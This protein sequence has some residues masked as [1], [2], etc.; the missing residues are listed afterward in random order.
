MLFTL[1]Q[2]K[3]YAPFLKKGVSWSKKKTNPTTRGLSAVEG[4]TAEQRADDL[5]NMLESIKSFCPVIK[6]SS[7]VDNSKCLDDV[8]QAIRLHYGFNTSGANFLDFT[9]IKP[10]PE[11]RHEDLYQ[12]MASFIDD[13]LLKSADSIVHDGD[14]ITE[15]EMITPSL[16]NLVVLLWL[17]KVH[18]KL[19]ALVKQKYAT[20]LKAKTIYTLKP[21]ISMAIPSLLDELAGIDEAKVMR[22]GGGMPRRTPYNQGPRKPM[23]DHQRKL[24]ECCLCKQ[25]GRPET[26]HWVSVCKFFPEKD[27]KFFAK[28]RQIMGLLDNHQDEGEY[29]SEEQEVEE[30]QGEGRGVNIRRVMIKSSPT[31][32]VFLGSRSAVITIDCGAE[33]DLM[34]KDVAIA[35]GIKIEKNTQYTTQADGRTPLNV[36]GEVHVTFT[37]GNHKFHFSGLV[38]ENLDVEI[39][40]GVPFQERN[41]VDVS[42]IRKELTLLDGTI[43]K[44]GAVT[45]SVDSPSSIRRAAV[46]RVGEA[47]VLWPGDYVDL[48]LDEPTLK[49]TEV[50]IEPK[51]SSKSHEWLKPSI[52]RSVDGVVRL[53]NSSK[54]PHILK[55]H[56]HIGEAAGVFTPKVSDDLPESVPIRATSVS[57]ADHVKDISVDPD[58]ILSAEMRERFKTLHKTYKEVFDPQFTGYNHAFGQFEAVV[59]MGNVKPPQRKGKLP[60]YSRNKLELVQEHFDKLEQLGVLA[61]PESVGVCIEYLNPSFL[62]KKK[63]DK[64]RMVTAFTE[65]GKYCKPQPTLLPTVDST[66]RTIAHW[67]YLITTDLKSA[68]Y[69]IPLSRDSMKYCGTASPFKGSRV[70]TRCAMGMPG[71]ESA[72]EELLSRI[73][74]DLIAKGH[75]A[76]I[77]DDLYCGGQTDEELLANWEATL[78]AFAA[79]NIRLTAPKTIIAPIRALLLGWI[80]SNGKLQASPHKVA[81]LSQC[82]R[83]T[84]VK[85]MRSFLGAYKVLARVIPK[86][87]SYLRNLNKSTAGKVSHQKIEWDAGLTDSFKSAQNHLKSNKIIQLP[88]ERDELF[89]VTDGATTHPTGIGA[90]L[91]SMRDEKLL[92]S[93]FF[94]Q[95]IKENQ[96]DKWFPCEIEGLAIAGAIKFWNAYIAQSR[97]R[98][99]VLTDSKP[100]R[101]AY[102]I[103]C[104]GEFS[105]NARLSTYLNT[106]SR[107]HVTIE[108][109][110]GVA[111]ALSDFSSRNPVPCVSD[112]CQVCLFTTNLDASVVRSLTVSDV[113]SGKASV[114]YTNRRAWA[115]TQA[116]CPELRRVKAQLIQGTRPSK[117]ETSI[118]NIKRYLNRVTIA[119]DG[120]LVVKRSDPLSP[121]KESIVIPVQVFPGLV[122][123]LHIKFDHPTPNELLS[124]MERDFY[125]LNMSKVIEEVSSNC[126]TCISLAKIPKS[127]T[128]QST[129][130]PPATFGIQFACDVIR[131]ERQMILLVREYISS[132]TMTTIIPSEKHED[133][134]SAI[135]KLV[136]SYVPLEGPYA[137]IRTDPAPGFK[138]LE[139]DTVLKKY[140]IHLEVGRA[141]NANKNPV[142]ERAVQEMEEVL[143]RMDNHNE[144][145]NECSLS[146]ATSRLNS[147][148]RTN[149]LS[150]RE[151]MTQRDQFSNNPI[152]INDKDIILEKHAKAIKDHEYSERSKSH[153]NPPIQSPKVNIGDLVHLYCDKNKHHPRERYLVTGVDGQWI[154]IRKFTGSQ[155]RAL[156]YKVK[157]TEVYKVPSQLSDCEIIK[158]RRE[159][160]VL[161][162]SSNMLSQEDNHEMEG[163]NTPEGTLEELVEEISPEATTPSDIPQQIRA[164]PSDDEQDTTIINEQSEQLATEEVPRRNPRRDRKRPDYLKDYDTK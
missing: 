101:D 48:E 76:K 112:K 58:Q 84:T 39:L 47:Q 105:S 164:P 6:K 161:H 120:L 81:A 87:S 142:A 95:Q 103:L 15:D 77:A 21:E 73:V 26:N 147:K 32:N 122:T 67:N 85:D 158:D 152:P 140:R 107:Y 148:I 46:L 121:T 131:R 50:A 86:C 18:P 159:P 162:E 23:R 144:A 69:Q 12:R 34:R 25:A 75:L 68:Y 91:Y 79:A 54:D 100:C 106:V 111:N 160:L 94:S 28:T 9:N 17:E 118:P 141:K 96:S 61:K 5:E 109:L 83:P 145:I 97:H 135:L 62:V 16:E 20:E 37:R 70:Y 134:R 31:M 8:W 125:A 35:L 80:W 44:Y 124:I 41:G 119:S 19:P 4:K 24:P 38:V 10:E 57:E 52:E 64:F 65:V 56:E 88:R 93:G 151:I 117:K 130:E 53:V 63:D 123:A 155:L 66:L 60:Q 163:S 154:Q 71:S 1:R 11:E 40:A 156:P 14:V 133:L 132:F 89:L 126:H 22:M 128:L 115:E 7:I 146:L 59:K 13:N 137:V 30:Y 45:K 104:R 42:C 29:E 143:Q 127:L 36:C 33:A 27:R 108:H 136:I 129:S 153:S 2:D 72:L 3:D 116:E 110:A 49:D 139:G 78:K 157:L 102:N 150:A 51:F 99:R 114:P 149:G 74:G 92:L 55:K 90:T 138:T 43:I 98:T 82:E 113:K